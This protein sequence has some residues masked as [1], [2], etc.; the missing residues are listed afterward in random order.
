MFFLAV[1]AEI[2]KMENRRWKS[3]TWKFCRTILEILDSHGAHSFING[4]RVQW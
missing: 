2:N 3:R 4:G 1:Q